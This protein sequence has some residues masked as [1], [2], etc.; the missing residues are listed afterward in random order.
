MCS[1]TWNEARMVPV[2]SVVAT[3]QRLQPVCGHFLPGIAAVPEH[4]LARPRHER[5][6]GV[7]MLG[8]PAENSVLSHP[9]YFCPEPVLVK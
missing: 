2:R 5:E 4:A 8:D 9:S 1:L 6:I 7:E 3:A